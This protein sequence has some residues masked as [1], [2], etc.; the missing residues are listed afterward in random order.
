MN[1]ISASSLFHFTKTLNSLHGILQNSFRY[2][3]C[4]EKYPS[5]II[6]NSLDTANPTE[7]CTQKYNGF[8]IPEIC[9]CD[10]PITRAQTHAKKYGMYA[11]GIDKIIA[12]KIYNN[13][14][15]PIFYLSS[16]R[17]LHSIIDLSVLK[18]NCFSKIDDKFNID[19]N[20]LCTKIETEYE[21]QIFYRNAINSIDRIIAFSKCEECKDEN[22]KFV[23]YYDE[24]EWRS[25]IYDRQNEN[26]NWIYDFG[27]HLFRNHSEFKTWIEPYNKA[28]HKCSYAYLPLTEEY[29]IDFLSQLVTHIIV[30]KESQIPSLINLIIKS[31]TLFGNSFNKDDKETKYLKSILISRITSFERIEKDY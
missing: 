24:R 31:D 19:K 25:V 16:T 30:K 27:E 8:A 22:D 3:Y 18:S 29:T 5:P 23:N 6:H 11:I 1:P 28:L 10:I 20:Y 9:F 12:K 26:S 2:S 17:L 14:I 15:N 4:L 21:K 13:N 7:L